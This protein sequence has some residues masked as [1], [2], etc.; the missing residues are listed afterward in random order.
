[1][2]DADTSVKDLKEA[3]RDFIHERQWEKYHNPKDL[4]ESISIEASELLQLFQWI[5]AEESEKFKTEKPKIQRIKEELSD[6]VIY[7]LSMANGLDIDLSSAILDKLEHNKSK[8]PVN[9]YKGKAH[10]SS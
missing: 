4:A 1:M 10:L 7:C 9:V 5:T 8:Y 6:V 2:S 3:V